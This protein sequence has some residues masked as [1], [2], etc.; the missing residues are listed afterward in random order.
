M[1]SGG[2][3]R[4]FKLGNL[5]NFSAIKQSKSQK[6]IPTDDSDNGVNY[7]IQSMF[8]NMFARKVNRQYLVDNNEAPV[9]GNKIV[10]GVTLPAVSYQPKEFGASQVI[11]AE[12]DWLN[13]K[14]GLFI[15]TAIEKLMY[16]FS[17]GNKPGLK[18]YKSMEIDLPA[19]KDNQLALSYMEDFIT[20]LQAERLQE[21][22]D[23][24]NV[25]GLSNYTLNEAERSALDL[26]EQVQWKEF[27]VGN[28]FNKLQSRFLGKGDKFKV[29][30]K[31]ASEEY[32]IPAV[33]AKSGDNGIMYWAKEGDFEAHSNVISIIYNGAI[34][35]GL[36]Y[37][38]PYDTAIL[39]ESYFIKY[40]E[41]E[42]TFNTN[43]FFKTVLE[44]VLYPRYS[45]DYLATWTDKVEKDTIVLP[46]LNN[47]IDLEFMRIFIEAMKK[48]VIADVV[49]YADQELEAYKQV[50][51]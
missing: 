30:S 26:F 14:N 13:P 11:T 20:E 42:V 35:T 6:D 49:K 31:F 48:L 23:Y 1:A 34:A 19:N 4:K 10:L 2:I 45:R 5:F 28:L 37:A 12:A 8:N 51:S 7:I 18:I 41:K 50:I 9:S 36:V 40:K 47:R 27:K 32:S 15:V 3:F 29:V 39:A 24:L 44:K 43:L 17:Y 25:A 46:V 38:Q 33:Y 22:Q 16:R 21:L